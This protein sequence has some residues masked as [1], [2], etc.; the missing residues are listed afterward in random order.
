MDKEYP[1]SGV[2]RSPWSVLRSY[3]LCTLCPVVCVN[4]RSVRFC[5]DLFQN[6]LGCREGDMLPP[7]GASVTPAPSLCQAVGQGGM[8]MCW[9]SPPWWGWPLSVQAG[10]AVFLFSPGWLVVLQLW[11]VGEEDRVFLSLLRNV[12]HWLALLLVEKRDAWVKLNKDFKSRQKHLW[13]SSLW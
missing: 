10:L 9:R 4:G 8:G 11:D 7:L 1:N 13:Y 5:T 6:R 3:L 2:K 12:S